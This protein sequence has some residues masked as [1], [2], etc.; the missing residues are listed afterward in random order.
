MILIKLLAVLSI[1]FGAPE[2]VTFQINSFFKEE[3]KGYDSFT[4]DPVN[5]PEDAVS[6]KFLAGKI[7]SEKRIVSIPA[8]VQLLSGQTIKTYLSFKLHLFRKALIA[9]TMIEKNALL[10]PE[11]LILETVEVNNTNCGLVYSYSEIENSVAAKKFLTGELICRDYIEPAPVIK[12]GDKV[13]AS[14]VSGST[15][16]SFDA[17]SRQDGRENEIIRVITS[18]KKLYKV[19]V[20]NSENVTVAE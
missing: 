14:L 13:K 15:V 18:D 7:D 17:I 8:E 1:L 5:L 11:D 12:A 10:R 20:I 3:L 6:V 2:T 16:I 4:V 9:G 19:K